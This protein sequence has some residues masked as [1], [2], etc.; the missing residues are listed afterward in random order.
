MLEIG[1]G[2]PFVMEISNAV[3]V[4]SPTLLRLIENEIN[5]NTSGNNDGDV[6]ISHLSLVRSMLVL[7]AK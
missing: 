6:K 2:R 4:P 5:N 1:N 3:G 7:L